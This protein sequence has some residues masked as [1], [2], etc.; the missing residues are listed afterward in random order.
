MKE[1][2]LEAGRTLNLL[3][4]IKRIGD[5]RKN[6]DAIGEKFYDAFIEDFLSQVKALQADVKKQCDGDAAAELVTDD[7]GFYNETI[8]NTGNNSNT[9]QSSILNSLTTTDSYLL[10][11]FALN[12]TPEDK[13]D[14]SVSTDGKCKDP[15]VLAK[16]EINARYIYD[17]LQNSKYSLPL[18]QLINSV[19]NRLLKRRIA[20][21]DNFVLQ[22]YRDEFMLLKHLRNIRKVLLLE[23]SDIMHQF[24]SNLFKQ[25]RI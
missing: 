4:E 10:M 16:K 9:T 23:A 13:G 6:F 1:H 2:S 25:V 7:S 15:N 20:F 18:E 24:Y 8:T 5:L 12:T 14:Q 21:A 11:A 3:Y 17:I 19:L 22:L